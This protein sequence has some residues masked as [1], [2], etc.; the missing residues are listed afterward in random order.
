[1][2]VLNY[3]DLL[4]LYL[5]HFYL[6]Y[7]KHSMRLEFYVIYGDSFLEQEERLRDNDCK[8]KIT[9]DSPAN[10]ES[11]FI[12]FCQVVVGGCY[13]TYQASLQSED[14]KSTRLNS[15]H[16]SISYAVFCL[17]KKKTNN[18]YYH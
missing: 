18:I 7:Y 14:R 2:Q 5:V 8:R 15:S 11:F 4:G 17:K 3:L 16:V 1:M 9:N 6:F 13:S 10:G 12:S